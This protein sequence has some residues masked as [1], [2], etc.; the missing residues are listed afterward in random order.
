MDLLVSFE[1]G[2]QDKRSKVAVDCGKEPY[3]NDLVQI[4]H[5]E[6]SGTKVLIE[7]VNRH[8]SQEQPIC[9]CTYDF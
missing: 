9:E 3:W 8:K 1:Y 5:Y 7:I 4:R 6:A 2:D